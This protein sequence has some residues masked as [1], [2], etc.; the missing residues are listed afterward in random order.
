MIRYEGP[1]RELSSDTP[2]ASVKHLLQGT[3]EQSYTD[4]DSKRDVKRR[5]I[6]ERVQYILRIQSGT[7]MG[8]VG[9]SAEIPISSE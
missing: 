9:V 8:W 3:K 4:T 6:S 7:V 1:P 2:R 5:A